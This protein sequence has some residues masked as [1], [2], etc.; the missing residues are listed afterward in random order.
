MASSDTIEHEIGAEVWYDE[1]KGVVRERHAS[2]RAGSDDYTVDWENG[3]STRVW[4]SD[5]L[6]AS[7]VAQS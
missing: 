6:S 7:E 4:G 2:G 3:A 5:L 1:A